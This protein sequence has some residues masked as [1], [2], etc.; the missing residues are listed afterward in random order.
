MYASF[1]KKCLTLIVLSNMLN[2]KM[3]VFMF[4]NVQTTYKPKG[5]F[6]HHLYSCNNSTYNNTY[7]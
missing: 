2:T 4:L 5:G 1:L 7:C 6:G 3:C